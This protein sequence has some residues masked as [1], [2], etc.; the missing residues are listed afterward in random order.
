MK[1]SPGQRQQKHY[2]GKQRKNRIRRHAE[3][4]RMYLGARHIAGKRNQLRPEPPL[5]HNR[6]HLRKRLYR[7]RRLG[8]FR[9]YYLG[10]NRRHRRI[11]RTREIQ[12]KHRN[13]VASISDA[14]RAPARLQPPS[15]PCSSSSP[16]P[17]P[18]RSPPHPPLPPPTTSPPTPH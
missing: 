12:P 13:S 17:P 15:R 18:I 10:N 2:K 1:D 3:C 16:A 7:R 4:I 14:S 5:P 9:R 6:L 8:R 11:G